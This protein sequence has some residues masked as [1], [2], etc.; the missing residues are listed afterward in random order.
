F[1]TTAMTEQVVIMLDADTLREEA[2]MFNSIV[3]ND[4]LIKPA[5]DRNV[6]LIGT[7]STTS[8]GNG[9]QMISFRTG[10]VVIDGSNNGTDTR[11]LLITTETQDTRVPIGLNTADADN[12]VLKNLIIKNI[13][14]PSVTVDFRY[15]VVINDLDGPTGLV[16]ENCQIGS[17]EHPIRRDG[18]APWAGN[19]VDPVQFSFVGNEIYAGIRGITTYVLTNSEIIGNTI[20]MLPA[21]AG[22]SGTGIPPTSSDA[23]NHGIYITGHSGELLI[24]DNTINMLEKVN[25]TSAYLMGIA[26]A[27]N[28]ATETDQIYVVNNMINVGAADET[29]DCFGIGLRSAQ[30]MGNIKAYHNTI[31]VNQT[32]ST[33][34]GYGV[35]NRSNGTGPVSIDLK[36]NIVINNHTG[37]TGSSAI[38]LIPTTSVL[39]SDNNVL[40]S[41]QN[42]VNLKGTTYADL[43][44]WQ[45]AGQDAGSVSKAVT[46][47]SATDMHL[48]D[49]SNKDLDLVMPLIPDVLTDIDGDARGHGDGLDLTYAGADEGTVF[50]TMNIVEDFATATDVANWRSDNSGSTVRTQV[51]SM[52]RLSDGVWTF[53]ARRNVS[54]TPNTFFKAT[55]KIKTVGSFSANPPA[56]YLHFG[57]DGLGDRV[58]QVSCI[59]DSVF[60][61][62]SVIGYA[63][64]ETGTLF[65]AGQGGAG[66]DTVWVDEYTYTNNYVPGLDVI[67]TV[68]EARAVP[69]GQK[70]ATIGVATTTTHFGTSGPVYIQD[71]TAGYA[72]YHYA[73]AQNVEIGD[74]IMA[75]GTQKNYNGLL[76]LDPT[77]DFIVLSKGNA[78]EPVEIVA[79][80]MDGDAYEGQ[81]VMIRGVDTLSTGL[82]W[83]TAVGQQGTAKFKDRAG[84]EFNA[85]LDKDTDIDGSPKPD[86]WPLNLVGIVSD[87][88]G[89]Q[90]MPRSLADFILA[91]PP[92]DFHWLKP[93]NNAV[94][95]SLDDPNIVDFTMG[96][97]TVKA[98][99]LEWTEAVDP[100]AEDTVTYEFFAYP[101]GPEESLTTLDTFMFIPINMEKPYEMNGTYNAYVTAS[102]PTGEVTYSDTIVIT[103]DFPAPPVVVNSDIVLV[104]GAPKFYAQFSIPV[105]PPVVANFKFVDWSNG[106]S[107]SDATGIDASADYVLISGNLL[108]DH[109]YSLAYSGVVSAADT[110]DNPLTAVD[111]TMGQKV[112]IP[113][114][115]AHPE[116]A[117]NMIEDFET[118]IG[119]FNQPY[120][121]GQSTVLNT[122][123]FAVSDE[124]AF[125]GTKS[126]KLILNDD[127]ATSGGW[128]VREYYALSKSVN[129]TSTI[130]VA[131]K[132]SN[133]N[134]EMRLSVKD[135]GYEQ[136]PWQRVTL[137]ED[138]WQIV[139]FDL[140]NDPAE[141]WVNGDGIIQGSTV[142]IEGIHF[143]CSEDTDVVLYIDGFV[144]RKAL[145]PVDVTLNVIMKKWHADG[146]FNLA[147]D[148]VDVAGS[149]NEWNGTMMADADGDT[150]YSVTMALMPYSSHAFKFRINSS[151]DDATSE[152]PSGGPNRE[153]TV[154]GNGGEYT[155]WYNNDTLE[156]A[157]V[158]VPK[159]FALHQNYP[160]P[161]NP[162]TTINFDLPTTADVK[163]V[164]YDIAGRKIR[165]LV[166]GHIDAG[167][168][169]IVWNGRDDWGNG[170][171][172]GMYI[173]RLVAGDFVDVK[174][175]TFLK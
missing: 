43:A 24:A 105:T 40:V 169:K 33:L 37:N 57:I 170:V 128:Y 19:G 166:N 6:V 60:T 156:V 67:S 150:T 134:V 159:E 119:T 175:M 3:D 65:I 55:A 54:A 100:D 142:Q 127:P 108:E 162:T 52:L 4:V 38:G 76:E 23:Y 140:L 149:F 126:G 153:L 20:N 59:S 172:T 41:S 165:T 91:N 73:T 14:H 99:Y 26:F 49:P 93:A 171:A 174:K 160:N 158:G 131:V 96:T 34:V 31:V 42:L 155:Y 72:V 28:G 151:W 111:T 114:S 29:R 15:G 35:G 154:P 61:T 83:P 106:G 75:I 143:R 101:N 104:A 11:N 98:L 107:V 115:A 168:K 16:V 25:S 77:L 116:D 145:S 21:T 141:G 133:A 84:T 13:D 7:P 66:A 86:K 51:D 64:N 130:M 27:G 109:W 9:G 95:T 152:F 58:Y 102:D 53:D 12:V 44:A 157:A 2:L 79:A 110:S 81:L 68:A 45:A 117:P 136:S 135:T 10:Y 1:D 132:G 56:Q 18:L 112:L 82:Y 92:G 63:V 164:I 121:S 8:Y 123:T 94:I 122:S 97:D 39:T 118:N 148:W 80:D 36:N 89:A 147:L 103:F 146:K 120:I 5:K 46:F 161:F 50:P 62:F 173:Y 70:L 69:V 22:H 129:T 163:L 138:D 139:S 167:Y 71:G 90:L 32:A 124:E 47:V 48:A 125:H 30:N 85:Y 88:N 113:F 144:E 87:Y 78:V 137:S 74:E 17:A